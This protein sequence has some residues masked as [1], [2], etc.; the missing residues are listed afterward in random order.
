[1]NSLLDLEQPRNELS[2][3]LIG[4]SSILICAVAVLIYPAYA[5]AVLFVMAIIALA[6]AIDRRFFSERHKN[7][8]AVEAGR[9]E[10]LKK[11]PSWRNWLARMRTRTLLIISYLSALGIILTFPVT[12]I[13]EDAMESVLTALLPHYANTWPISYFAGTVVL[14]ETL[15]FAVSAVV[16]LIISSRVYDGKK[17][18]SGWNLVMPATALFLGATL[19][20]IYISV[21]SDMLLAY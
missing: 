18:M 19:I 16:L 14:F 2:G 20:L 7:E 9:I 17:A 5:K 3:D 15:L 21:F 12:L 8:I 13:M 4:A 11:S 1:M 6:L 10:E